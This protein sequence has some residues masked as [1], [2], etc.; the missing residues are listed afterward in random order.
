MKNPLLVSN[1]RPRPSGL[2]LVEYD[3]KLIDPVSSV[4]ELEEFRSYPKGSQ[5]HLKEVLRFGV[6]PYLYSK[7]ESYSDDS[8]GSDYTDDSGV[9]L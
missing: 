7:W 9:A 5:S 1:Q 2:G 3:D 6:V 4:I 8:S